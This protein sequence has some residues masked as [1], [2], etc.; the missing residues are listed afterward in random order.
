MYE[1]RA[2]ASFEKDIARLDRTVA[3]RILAKC[4]FLAINPKTIRSGLK[5]LPRELS[6]LSKCRVGDWRILFWVDHENTAINLVGVEH[7]RE[8]YRRLRG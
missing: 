7:R 5:Y 4:E 2:T 1:L 3:K 6:G 8:V